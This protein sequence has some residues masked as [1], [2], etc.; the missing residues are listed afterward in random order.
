[1]TSD[2]LKTRLFEWPRCAGTGSRARAVSGRVILVLMALLWGAMP[3]AAHG[4]Y[5]NSAQLIVREGTLELAIT[6]GMD[7]AKDV[8]IHAGETEAGANS[9]LLTRGPST[10]TSLPTAFAAQL[11]ELGANGVSLNAD[12]VQVITDGLEVC[13]VL[14]Y[15]RPTTDLL[16]LRAH[17]FSAVKKLD[18]AALVAMDE[19]R[20]ILDTVVL[21]RSNASVELPVPESPDTVAESSRLNPPAAALPVKVSASMPM[22]AAPDTKAKSMRLV[23]VASGLL[24]IVALWVVTRLLLQSCSVPKD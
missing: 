19:N 9:I 17:Y 6:L 18:E 22:T 7:A 4:P 10:L 21:S 11:F 5:D 23:W 13:F 12:A 2:S 3:V 20:N 14:T 24:S 15:P 8:L 16:D 1:M